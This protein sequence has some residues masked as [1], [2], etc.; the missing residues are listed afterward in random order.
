MCVASALLALAA[1]LG[2]GCGSGSSLAEASRPTLASSEPAAPAGRSVASGRA[3]RVAVTSACAQAYGYPHDAVKLRASYLSFEMKQGANRAQLADIEKTYD[4]ATADARG[5]QDSVCSGWDGDE[6][7][8][9]VRRYQ[10]GN[11][12]Q[13][14]APANASFD[15]K[16]F[17]DNADCGGRC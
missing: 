1:V 6:L 15:Q 17:W 2:G 3:T 13:R 12:S 9:D 4:A 5:R 14:S 10:A 16:A 8:G 11:F 7:R